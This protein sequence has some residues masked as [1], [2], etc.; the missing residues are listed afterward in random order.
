M[1]SISSSFLFLCETVPPSGQ[2]LNMGPLTH[3]Q[4]HTLSSQRLFSFIH[5]GHLSVCTHHSAHAHAA[6]GRER[7]DGSP[8]GLGIHERYRLVAVGAAAGVAADLAGGASRQRA[9]LQQ[10]FQC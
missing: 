8:R 9:I 4:T 7:L 1:A 10:C 3:T 2:I 5:P 6:G